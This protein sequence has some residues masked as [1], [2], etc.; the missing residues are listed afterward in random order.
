MAMGGTCVP[1][2]GVWEVGV[3]DVKLTQ[4]GKEVF[5]TEKESIVRQLSLSPENKRIHFASGL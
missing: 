3:V 5:S 4:V 2:G 1:N